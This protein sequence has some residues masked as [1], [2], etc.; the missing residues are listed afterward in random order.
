MTWQ[1]AI[2]GISS[3]SSIGLAAYGA[4]GLRSRPDVT[5]TKIKQFE[6]ANRLHLMH[7]MALMFLPAAIPP[8]QQ[9][10]LRLSSGC[11]VGGTTLF[12][13]GVYAKVLGHED[14]AKGAPFGGV[15]MMCGWI[16]AGLLRR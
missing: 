6:S 1:R 13:G 14:A 7:S 2:G 8:H 10:A 15:L 5:D 4:H 9:L 12:S 16:C 3:A 11:F